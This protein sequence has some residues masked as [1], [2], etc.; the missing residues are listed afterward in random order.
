VRH[1]V[2]V[3][4]FYPV[5]VS[6]PGSVGKHFVDV[7]APSYA[8]YTLLHRQYGF[9]LVSKHCIVGVNTDQKVVSQSTGL[10]E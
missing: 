7:A 1:Q 10:S 8:C 6:D 3:V 4:F 2:D 5:A 9:A